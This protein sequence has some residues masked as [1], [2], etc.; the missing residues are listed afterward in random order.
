GRGQR[1]GGSA[2]A[3]HR[4]DR[5]ARGREEGH[6]GRRQGRLCR[7]QS[8]RLRH[9]DDAGGRAAAKN[10]EARPRRSRRA[11]RNLPQRARAAL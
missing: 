8:K 6:R 4:A 9:Q 10:G 11:A 5:A 1:R 7:S 3:V 2:A